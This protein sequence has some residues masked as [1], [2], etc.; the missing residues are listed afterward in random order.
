MPKQPH[1]ICPRCNQKLRRL[2][3]HRMDKKKFSV[4]CGIATRHKAGH[5]AVKVQV[6]PKLIPAH[7]MEQTMQTDSVHFNRLKWFKLIEPIG[8]RTG[9][10]KM[11]Q[12]GWDFLAGR[13]SVPSFILCREGEVVKDSGVPVTVNEIKN[14]VLDKDY[15][16]RYSAGR[17]G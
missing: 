11:T 13:A 9:F 6:D 5:P 7:E 2:N 16:D 8:E 15:W 10:Y 3:K 17:Q 12:L 1:D 4:L 14:L